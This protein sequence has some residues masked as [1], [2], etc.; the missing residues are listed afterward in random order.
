MSAISLYL[1]Y[2]LL[3]LVFTGI[4]RSFE[5]VQVMMKIKLTAEKI[6]FYLR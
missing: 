3:I 5:A 4:A 6:P 2:T 1:V